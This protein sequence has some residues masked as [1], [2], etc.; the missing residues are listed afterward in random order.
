MF[1]IYDFFLR[2]TQNHIDALNTIDGNSLIQTCMHMNLHVYYFTNV[3][4]FGITENTHKQK[5]L[6]KYMFL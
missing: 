3:K 2:E 5:Y 4:L 1:G 6:E